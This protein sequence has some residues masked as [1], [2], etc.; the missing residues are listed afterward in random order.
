MSLKTICDL[1]VVDVRAGRDRAE[2]RDAAARRTRRRRGSRCRVLDEVERVD[3]VRQA[4]DAALAVDD[5]AVGV[6]R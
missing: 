2:E 6:R 1:S 3:E 4:G 5:V